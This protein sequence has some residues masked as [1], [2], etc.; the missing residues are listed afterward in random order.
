MTVGSRSDGETD[1]T[2]GDRALVEFFHF[3]DR[4]VDSTT[5]VHF[6]VNTVKLHT[7]SMY[8]GYFELVI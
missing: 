4:R 2:V 3:G 7:I 1:V 6:T 8:D 5:F